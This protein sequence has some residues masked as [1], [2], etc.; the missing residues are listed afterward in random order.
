M[1]RVRLISYY[2]PQY[3]TFKENDEWWG[4]GFTE[5]VN[6][7][8]ATSLFS[9]HHQPHI[10]YNQLFYELNRNHHHTMSFQIGLAKKYGIYGFCF[11]HY[12]FKDGKKLLE[13][14]VEKFLDDKTLDIHF[15]LSWANEPWTRAWD[16]GNKE[17]IM[18]QGYGG[19]EEWKRHFNYLLPFLLDKRYIKINEKPILVIYRPELIEPLNEMLE[20]WN[21]LA[22]Q[23]GLKGL[24]FISQG[25]IY[26]TSKNKSKMISSYIMYEPGFTQASFSIRRSNLLIKLREEPRL[27]LNIMSQKI[28]CCLGAVLKLKTPWWR[29]T[30]LSYDLIWNSILKRKYPIDGHVIPGAFTAWDNSPR[31]GSNGAKIIKGASPEKF[32]HYF[33]LLCEKT[34]IQSNQDMIFITAWNEWAEGAYLEPDQENG[35]AYLEAIRDVLYE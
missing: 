16:G 28:K 11:Y 33:K 32:K 2:L 20:L 27:L 34:L 23:A 29:T 17:I 31:R 12:W 9:W 6:V 35:Y 14:P 5:W 25:S 19:L 30:I 10:P 22:I 8:K 24:Y 7:K 18:P 21:G 3:Y 15:C 26:G 1:Q 13:I 4:E